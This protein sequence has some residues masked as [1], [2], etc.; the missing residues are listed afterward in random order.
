MNYLKGAFGRKIISFGAIE[1][2]KFGKLLFSVQ[3]ARRMCTKSLPQSG[4]PI[5]NLIRESLKKLKPIH[6]ETRN[7]S[8]LHSVPKGSET[9]FKILIVSKDFES[10]PLIERHRIVNK[11]VRE[12]LGKDNYPHA[13]SI[14]AR[15]PDEYDKDSVMTPTP[16]CKGG[17]G[18]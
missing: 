10:L 4:G 3:N 18:M 6:C 1:H 14:E 2:H 17:F 15:T 12:A 16:K 11:T 7:D 8:Y 13:L 9:H 5:E